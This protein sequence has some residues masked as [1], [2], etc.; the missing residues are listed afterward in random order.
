MK[1]SNENENYKELKEALDF[2]FSVQDAIVEAT[3]D[4][5]VNGSD[6]RVLFPVFQ[7]AK[8]GFEGLG[9]PI[10]RWKA[11]PSELREKLFD[12]A[13]ERFDLPNNLLE[14]LIE[15]TLLAVAD[16]VRVSQRWVK[17]A[18]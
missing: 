11:L 5:E 1:I 8:E 12:Y 6:I 10:E 3:A 7:T 14:I 9:N 4:G 13:R 16:V 2:G 17:F 15:D 18:K